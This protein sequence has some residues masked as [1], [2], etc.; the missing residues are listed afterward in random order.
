VSRNILFPWKNTATHN[1][2]HCCGSYDVS[3]I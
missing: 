3:Q 2:L 1:I